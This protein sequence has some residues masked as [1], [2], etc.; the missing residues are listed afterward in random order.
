MISSPQ[1]LQGFSIT[2]ISPQSGRKQVLKCQGSTQGQ[3]AQLEML[4]EPLPAELPPWK[5]LNHL[6][7]LLVR[8]LPVSPNVCKRKNFSGS[9]QWE[10]KNKG[11]SQNSQNSCKRPPEGQAKGRELSQSNVNNSIMEKKS[12]SGGSHRS[13]I[14][15]GMRNKMQMA[16]SEWWRLGG[17]LSN[18]VSSSLPRCPV[19]H[20]D[21]APALAGSEQ[22]PQ[23]LFLGLPQSPG[24]R[25][26]PNSTG[27]GTGT[28]GLG[29]SFL[30]SDGFTL[31]GAGTSSK[32][33][34]GATFGKPKLY[35]HQDSFSH[36]VF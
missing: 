27:L 35:G 34:P 31:N 16:P 11:I 24:H 36:P 17:N 1:P 20:R 13:H 21:T 12:P 28:G 22:H 32:Q 33:A 2:Q 8:A 4:Q 6:K 23:H 14:G 26:P 18:S 15:T 19:G 30:F 5:W 9:S 7:T 10:K 29:G 25:A 3:N